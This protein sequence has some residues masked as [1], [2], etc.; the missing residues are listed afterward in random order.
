MMKLKLLHMYPNVLDLYGD[1]GNV[2]VLKY[3]CSQR[4]IELEVHQ[5]LM[6]KPDDID[7]AAMDIIYLGGG[8]DYEQ[9]LLAE[10]LMSCRDKMKAAYDAGVFL[11]MI[12]GGYQLLGQYYKDSNGEEIPG[13]GLFSYHTEAS[14]N[15]RSRCIGNIVIETTLTGRPYKV[16]GFENHGGQTTGVKTPFGKVLCG[17]GNCWS[18]D[19]EGYIEDRVIATYLHG[20]LL[21]KNP[22][23]ADH[24][25][26]KCLE[27]KGENSSLSPLNDKLEEDCR[28]M[29]FKRLLNK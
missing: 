18:S 8:A 12:C 5:H 14:R 26:A 16:I 29:L 25:I 3:R 4:G 28:K 2:E 17:N 1:S 6:D 24:I 20:P 11:L 22:A 9:Q 7:F 19:S 27:R 10:D 21:S 13:L 15:K 23:L